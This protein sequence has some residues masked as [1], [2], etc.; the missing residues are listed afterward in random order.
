MEIDLAKIPVS[1][2]SATSLKSRLD[3]LLFSESQSRFIV[4]INPKNKEE[5]E[6][7]FAGHP[8][9][10]IGVINGDQNFV[11]KNG[12]K[13]IIKTNIATLNQSYRKTFNRFAE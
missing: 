10:Q 2:D 3:H 4:T 7:N 1:S 11:L 13:E 5:F 12:D 6:K 8:L 9:A